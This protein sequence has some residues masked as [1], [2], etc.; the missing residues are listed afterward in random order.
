MKQK[1]LKPPLCSKCGCEKYWKKVKDVRYK[2]GGVWRCRECGNARNRALRSASP[3]KARAKNRAWAK[4]N[5]EK[6]KAGD[7]AYYVAN[8]EKIKAGSNSW[9]KAN[10]EKRKTY[11]L[12]WAK[13]NPEKGAASVQRRRARKRAATSPLVTVTAAIEAERFAL[14][15]GCAY[16]GVDAKKTVDHVVPFKLSG[17]HVPSNIVGACGRCNSSKCDRPV[18]EW[19]RAQP[20]FSEQRWQ[21]IQTITGNGQLSLI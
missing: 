6:K 19:Y 4:A 8:R 1:P 20:F 7:R 10:P 2:A 9:A 5:P 12:A 3:E 21:R 17:L 14:T 16:C 11:C 13:A 15:D 18:E